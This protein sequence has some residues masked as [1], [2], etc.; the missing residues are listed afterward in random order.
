MVLKGED[1]YSF[2]RTLLPCSGGTNGV[3]HWNGQ[4][5]DVRVSCDNSIMTCLAIQSGRSREMSSMQKCV[6]VLF[7]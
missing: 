7:L 4:R 2:S 3:K 5:R 1:I 6:R